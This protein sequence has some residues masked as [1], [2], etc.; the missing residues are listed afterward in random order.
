MGVIQVSALSV[1]NNFQSQNNQRPTPQIKF[2]YF[3]GYSLSF[4]VF[5]LRLVL[6][7]KKRLLHFLQTLTTH[8]ICLPL[9]VYPNI[10]FPTFGLC[11]V[12]FLLDEN[13][14]FSGTHQTQAIN[15]F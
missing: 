5:M 2:T 12:T 9:L 8:L 7:E 14:R 6:D 10:S 11:A 13:V 15:H 4:S 1:N 3:S